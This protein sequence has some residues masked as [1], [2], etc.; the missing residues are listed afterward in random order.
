MSYFLVLLCFSWTGAMVE[1]CNGADLDFSG[2]DAEEDLPDMNYVNAQ[3]ESGRPRS[4]TQLADFYLALS[5][6]TNAVIW[7]VKA[8]E[9]NHVPAQLSLAGCLLSGRGVEKNPAAASQWLRRAA[10]LIEARTPTTNK[11]ARTVTSPPLPSAVHAPQIITPSPS[12]ASLTNATSTNT[13]PSRPAL[14]ASTTKT[15]LPQVKRINT[16]LAAEPDLL[17][18]PAG[19]R[20][21]TD[22]R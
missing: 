20:A 4:Q 15:N 18:I 5:D 14:V 1:S 17:E 9:Q 16:L 12:T 6:F 19:L 22:S 7:Y 3:A 11:L 13:I 10:D 2:V 21:P 8:A